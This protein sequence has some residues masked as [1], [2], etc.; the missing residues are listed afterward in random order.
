MKTV[1]AIEITDSH[2]VDDNTGQR[3]HLAEF[4]IAYFENVCKIQ[5]ADFI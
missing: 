1:A 3:N 5:Y 2:T 4:N